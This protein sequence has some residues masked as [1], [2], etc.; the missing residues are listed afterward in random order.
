MLMAVVAALS[1]AFLYSRPTFV[2]ISADQASH[3]IDNEEDTFILDVRTRSEYENDGHI[4]GANLIPHDEISHATERLPR[5]KTHTIL[6]YCRS[7][8]RSRSASRQ[9]AELGYVDVRNM[10]G[11]FNEWSTRGFPVVGGP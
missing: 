10:K 6:V 3:L 2:S 11:G 7:G 4:P 9:L 5:N 1:Y 8:R